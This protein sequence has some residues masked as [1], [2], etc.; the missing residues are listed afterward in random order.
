M[1][2]RAVSMGTSISSSG[3]YQIDNRGF[4]QCRRPLVDNGMSDSPSVRWYSRTHKK[5]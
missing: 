1:M 5:T 4:A 3:R 2:R